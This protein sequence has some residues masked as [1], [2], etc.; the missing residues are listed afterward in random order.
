MARW[1]YNQRETLRR[2]QFW[3]SP[4]C[5][6]DCVFCLDDLWKPGRAPVGEPA[7]DRPDLVIGDERLDAFLADR[8]RAN[9]VCI[10]GPDPG[11][12]RD[13]E[14]IVARVRA[15]GFERVAIVTNGRGL[16]RDGVARALVRAGVTRFE[17]S[18]H[19][20]RAEVH[21]A[22][23]RRSG[24][25][26]GAMAGLRAALG[27]RNEGG[28]LQV[29]LVTVVYRANLD[30][31]DET[32]GVLLAG[33]PDRLSV[34]VVEPRGEALARF[35]DVVPPLDAA[36]GVLAALLK[37]YGGHAR[38]NVDG[39]PPC[40][41]PGYEGFLGNREAVDLAGSSGDVFL[42]ETPDEG[43]VFAADCS[44]CLH[45]PVCNGV[46]REQAERHG[47]AVL[48]PVRVRQTEQA[49]DAERRGL[50]ALFY[51]RW[52]KRYRGHRV[53][54]ERASLARLARL[55]PPAT[56]LTLRGTD[57]LGARVEVAGV[58]CR[59]RV[60]PDGQVPAPFRAGPFVLVP[61]DATRA[62]TLGAALA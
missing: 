21:D 31:L 10:T 60:T 5:N 18:I 39:V 12:C 40:L 61:D 30:A 43:R 17:L 4:V 49:S 48:R 44:A 42:H 54:A 55:L 38:L 57:P 15:L 7:H 25:F 26:A 51:D 22:A 3:V 52:E 45:R 27:V 29:E 56:P 36:A 50:L 41:L 28:A 47:L 13:L 6:N 53:A 32:V 34:N 14:A 2:T 1:D 59:L 24:S 58:P 11:A 37:R 33:G 9:E 35:D 62:A 16:A 23:T 20:G 46:Y 8:D 19:G